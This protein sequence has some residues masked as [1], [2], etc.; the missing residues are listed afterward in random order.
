MDDD[1]AAGTRLG[2]TAIAILGMVGLRGPST[3]YE[4][5]RAVGRISGEF[6][7]VPH[8]VV[9]HET[10][11]LERAGL[12]TSV[13]E[14]EG[15][16]RRVYSLTDA[17]REATRGW[18]AEP[19]VQGMQIRDEAQLQLMFAEL[20]DGASVFALAEAQVAV[21]RNRLRSLDEAEAATVSLGL[22]PTRTMPI[23]LGRKV[24][25]AGLEF[26]TEVRDS[27][28]ADDSAGRH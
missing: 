17:G 7:N 27:A 2:G 18:L 23:R 1:S 10:A 11:R 15:R 21:Y 5:R 12:L 3:A 8:A 4:I 16:R 26:W 25:E 20:T 28:G 19:D 6:W 14:D 9:Y 22:P 13:Q 24:Y